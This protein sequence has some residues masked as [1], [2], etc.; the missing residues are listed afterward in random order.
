MSEQDVENLRGA[1]RDFN[2][3]KPETV[4][5]LSDESVEWTEPGGGNAPGGTFTGPQAVGEQVFAHI[6]QNFDEFVCSPENF[7]DQGDTVVVTGRFRGRT[8]AARTSTPPSPTHSSSR[9]ARSCG[10]TTRP[11]RA[12]QPAGPESGCRGLRG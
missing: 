8:R 6:P 12:G 5:A 9:T 7:D 11:T 3:G 2:A 10:S 4:L 1:Y